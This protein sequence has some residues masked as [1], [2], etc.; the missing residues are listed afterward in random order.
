MHDLIARILDWYQHSLATG[1]YPLIVLLMAMESSIVPLPSEVIIPPAVIA[2]QK[3]GDLS[4]LGIVVAG[5]IGSWLGATLMYWGARWAGRP[6]V[7]RYGRYLRLTPA[8]V[9]AAEAWS[10][11][12]G[13]F[14]VFASRFIPVIRH[15]IG[16]PAGIVRQNYWQFSLYTVLGSACWCAVLAWVGVQAGRDAALMHGELHAITL[17]VVGGL[18]IL[19]AIYYFLVHRLTR[20]AAKV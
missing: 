14:G 10:S 15:L 12:F 1:G 2:A 20:P 13:G 8:K 11:R 4:I 7:F 17:W 9:T 5:T 6:L 19:G 3:S 16:I 18:A